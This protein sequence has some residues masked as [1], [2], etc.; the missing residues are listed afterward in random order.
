MKSIHKHSV[1]L[2]IKTLR[3]VSEIYFIKQ[4]SIFL[5]VMIYSLFSIRNCNSGVEKMWIFYLSGPFIWKED[6]ASSGSARLFVI[7][8]LLFFQELISCADCLGYLLPSSNC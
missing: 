1:V 8:K 7:S 5:F 6:V 3:N 2:K 4:C